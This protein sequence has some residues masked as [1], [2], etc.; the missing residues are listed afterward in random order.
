MS[1]MILGQ[2]E[3]EDLKRRAVLVDIS[4]G[5]PEEGDISYV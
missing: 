2:E 5:K 4:E 1:G 3:G